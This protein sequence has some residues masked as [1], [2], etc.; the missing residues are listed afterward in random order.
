M[1]TKKSNTQE[2]ADTG[3]RS[4]IWKAGAGISAVFAAAIPS[5]A[6]PVI[7]NDKKLKNDIDYL[8][9][10]VTSLENEKQIRELHKTYE[11]LLDR[12]MYSEVLNLFTDDAE[13]V[14]NGGVYKGKGGLKRLFCSH[15]NSG[16][17]GKRTDQA[18]GFQ[19]NPEQQ[20]DVVEVSPDHKSAR[21]SYTYSIQVGTLIKSDFPLVKMARLHGEGIMKWWEGGLYE[22][23]Y[24]KNAR[25]GNWKIRRFEYRVLSKADYR[26]GR[27]YAKPISVP[28]FSE[29]YPKEPTGPDK[30]IT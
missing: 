26:P 7:S 27:T 21:A 20:Q 1:D 2:Q 4:F 19:L 28:S 15:F 30:L 3:R 23:A 5:I 8:S 22:V 13:V 10:Q 6:K 18:P 16:M 9:K 11:D 12:G 25:N 14:F 17:T 29:V 24:V